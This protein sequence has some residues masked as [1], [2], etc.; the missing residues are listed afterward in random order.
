LASSL[1]TPKPTQVG[2]GKE[3]VLIEI[4]DEQ[5]KKTCRK[6]GKKKLGRLSTFK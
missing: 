4:G 1:F 3:V 5:G 6:K 2:K